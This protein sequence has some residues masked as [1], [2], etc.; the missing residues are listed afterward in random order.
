[1]KRDIESRADIEL[2]VNTFYEKV[3]PDPVIGHIFTAV[4]KVNWKNYLPVMYDFWENV[5]L[6]TGSYTGNPIDIH[7]HIHHQIPLKQEHFQQW[8]K[9]FGSTVDGLFSGNKATLAKQ[10]ALSISNIIQ[11][12]IMEISKLAD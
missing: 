9:L 6:Y 4:A 2:L 1:M 10:R 11:M 8:N 12:K 7:R 5:L 3:K